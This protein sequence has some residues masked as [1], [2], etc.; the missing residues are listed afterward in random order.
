MD[1]KPDVHLMFRRVGFVEGDSANEAIRAT[2]RLNPE[3]PGQLDIHSLQLPY[4]TIP[5]RARYVNMAELL[6]DV[7]IRR[8]LGTVIKDGIET[9]VPPNS[10]VLRLGSAG[11]VLP[12][13][14]GVSPRGAPGKKKG[15]K[16]SP[17]ESVAL[18]A[19]TKTRPAMCARSGPAR[20]SV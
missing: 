7:E 3:L 19:H 10:H 18:I 15:I 12:T 11:G 13:G 14:E 16:V 1:V 20:P 4:S 2:R 8:I 17:G 6:N 5:P 9:S